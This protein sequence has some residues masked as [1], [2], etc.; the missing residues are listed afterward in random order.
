MQFKVPKFLEQKAKIVGPLTFSQT[1]YFTVAGMIIVVL[2]YL[3]PFFLFLVLAIVIGGAALSL[4]FVK[5]ENVPLS[6]VFVQ[7]FS[8]F[9]S[10]RIY[11]WKKKEPLTQIKLVEKKREKKEEEKET[12]LKI[13]PKSRLKRLASKIEVGLR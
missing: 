10:P 2:Y 3:L 8:Y 1:I 9:L 7:S 4:V 13:S 12:P 6:Q 11:L 5:I